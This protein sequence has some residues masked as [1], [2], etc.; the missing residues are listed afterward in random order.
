[1]VRDLQALVG[2]P[3]RTEGDRRVIEAFLAGPGVGDV[4]AGLGIDAD[5]IRA[6][7]RVMSGPTTANLAE[8]IRDAADQAPMVGGDTI[9]ISSTAIIIALLVLILISV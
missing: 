8:R 5:R 2:T 6:G 9:V 1:V 4:V 7:A 3:D